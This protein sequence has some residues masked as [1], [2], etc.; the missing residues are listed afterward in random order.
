M[1]KMALSKKKRI[2]NVNELK[3][4]A[5]THYN[6]AQE[7]DSMLSFLS[8]W[9]S[10]REITN[11][12]RLYENKIPGDIFEDIM[13]I[14][15]YEREFQWRLRDAIERI[16]DKAI[17]ELKGSHRNNKTQRFTSFYHE[18]NFAQKRFSN[19]TAAFAQAAIARVAQI[20][21]VKYSLQETKNNN[22][23]LNADIDSMDGAQ[24]EEW[25]AKLL[26]E[27]GY[28]EV[29]RTG[30]SGDQG[31]DLLAA[32]DGV[33][34]AIQ[35]KCYSSDLGNT[36]IQEVNVGKVIY[37]CQIGAV[38]TNRYFTDGGRIAAE[39][40]G[41][42]LWDR[43]WIDNAMSTISAS[44]IGD[45]LKD[46]KEIKPEDNLFDAAVDVILSTGEASVAMI[47]RKL[48][49]GYA[50][51]ARLLDEMEEKGIVG[52]YRGSLPRVIFITRDEWD[53]LKRQHE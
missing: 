10:L 17:Y 4:V 1:K 47:Q 14:Q 38:M 42:L 31:V 6:L 52:S 49:L 36:P 48:G 28:S 35:C 2:Q 39:A 53:K 7:T 9:D 37:R 24:F 16:Q 19:E 32:K 23:V 45:T 25:C 41:T 27:L 13:L 44:K 46:K 29:T 26:S 34:Y 11:E 12:L 30:K 18:I 3:W 43:A 50:R 20:A 21:G 40:T 51:A 8:H 33:R 15:V 22:N 5:I